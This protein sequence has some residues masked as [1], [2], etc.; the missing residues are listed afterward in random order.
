[1]KIIIDKLETV[2]NMNNEH[3]S[4]INDE[5]LKLRIEGVRSSSIGNQIVCIARA[6]DAYMKSILEDKGFSW[7]PDFPYEDR[8]DQEKMLNHMVNVGNESISKLRTIKEFS[9]NQL[10]LIMDLIG[11]E[12]QHQGQLIRYYY[13]NDIEQAPMTKSFWHLED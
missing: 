7:D 5:Q 3:L 12:Y 2:F 4:I 9:N 6:R 1:M 8:Y 13:A 10:D 11:H